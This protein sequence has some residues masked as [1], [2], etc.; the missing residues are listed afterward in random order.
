MTPSS[1]P[2]P[3]RASATT[4]SAGALALSR[5]VCWLLASCAALVPLGGCAS[6]DAS[7]AAKQRG[8]QTVT[9]P[10]PYTSRTFVFDTVVLTRRDA[11]GRVP[12][13]DVD[14]KT[15]G[16]DDAETCNKADATAPD[17]TPGIDNQ[18]ATLVPLIE[19]AGLGALEGLVQSSIDNGSILLLLD[20]ADVQDWQNDPSVK[21]TLRAAAGAPLLGTDGLLLPGQTFSLSKRSPELVIPGGRIENGVFRTGTF[22][23]ALPI[24]VF[25]VDYSLDMRNAQVQASVL[26]PDRMEN[27][28]VGG[29]ITLQSIE[30]LAAQAAMGE[31]D[32]DELI[33]SLVAGVGDLAKDAT[34]QC[35]QVSAALGFTAVSAYLYP[36]PAPAAP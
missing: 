13:F 34:G 20:L 32:L 30:V 3:Y 6:S 24:S 18:F 15:S 4:F 22:D 14:G 36:G 16:E 31:A 1:S 12:G 26:G 23:G 35:T 2:N 10:D 9:Q 27:G 33:L 28:L 25:G 11:S 19:L 29:G 21:V 17:G 7:P 8:D 5:A